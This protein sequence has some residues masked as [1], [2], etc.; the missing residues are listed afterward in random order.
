MEKTYSFKKLNAGSFNHENIETIETLKESELTQTHKNL[1][2][3]QLIKVW[4]ETPEELQY[5]FLQELA[6]RFLN[7]NKERI[8]EEHKKDLEKYTIRINLYGS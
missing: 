7:D 3:G 5:K 8:T 2:Y 4:N 6:S 1:L